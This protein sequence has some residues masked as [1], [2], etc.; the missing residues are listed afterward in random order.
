MTVYEIFKYVV[1]PEKKEQ[2]MQ[3]IKKLDEYMKNNPE[4]FKEL[5][6]WKLLVQTYG[7]G[8]YGCY[9]EMWGFDNS[10]EQ[11]KFDAKLGAD[12][13]FLKLF[14]ELKLVID[15][16]TFTGRIWQSVM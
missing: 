3:L 15:P 8:T 16:V 4:L 5:K 12:Q 14:D 11:A 6:S 10:M 9:V 13:G 7:D 1:K 2:Y